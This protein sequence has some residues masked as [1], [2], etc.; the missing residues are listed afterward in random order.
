MNE[1][2]KKVQQALLSIDTPTSKKMCK[3]MHS[4][5]NI[6]WR[7]LPFVNKTIDKLTQNSN[8]P[9]ILEYGENQ[10][11]IIGVA[12]G[13]VA[14]HGVSS[15]LVMALASF[16]LDRIG[17]NNHSPSTILQRKY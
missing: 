8:N 6:W 4:G 5:Y 15:A 7:F 9:G 11:N 17:Q 3:K 16:S 2:A 10:N 13:D 12:I 14:G 1:T